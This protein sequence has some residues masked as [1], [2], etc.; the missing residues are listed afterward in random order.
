M[1]GR[2]PGV[3][4]IESA[5]GCCSF[6]PLRG[7]LRVSDLEKTVSAQQSAYR[8]LI[9]ILLI[10][11]LFFTFAG[12]PAPDVNEAHYLAKAKHYWQPDWCAGD[13]F[14]ESGEAH[15]FFYWTLG[16]LNLFLP[17]PAVA[18][19]GRLV[20][21]GALAWAWQRLSFAIVPRPMMSVLTAGLFLFFLERFH[22]AGEWVVGGVEA[23]G[24]A[25]VL[26]LLALEAMTRGRWR[27]VWIFLGLATSLHVLVGGWSWFAAGWA[28]LVCG[29]YRPPL[30]SLLP[31]MA[32]GLLL[33]L[34]GLIAAL[35]LN[36]GVDPAVVREADSLYVYRRLA[37]HLVFH[38][39]PHDAMARHATLLGIWLAA[40]WLSPCRMSDQR[41]GQRPLRGFVVGAV[42]LSAIGI[43]IDQS[44]L[45]R[46][47]LA[48]PLLKFY[49]YRLA[50]AA[51]P[52]GAALALAGLVDHWWSQR[53][54]SARWLL[55][56][57]TLL[58]AGHLGWSHYQRRLDFR[59]GA[60]VQMLPRWPHDSARTR[61]KYED[62][63]YVCGWIEKNT[64]ADSVFVTPRFQQTFKWYAGRAEVCA[65]KDIPQ[66][67]ASLVRWW[68][69][70]R[71]LYSGAVRR[72][73]LVMH[74]EQRLVELS[75]RYGG[76][77]IVLD[78]DFS[79]RGL[80]LPRVFPTPWDDPCSY[81][82]YRVPQGSEGVDSSGP[83][84]T[85]SASGNGYGSLPP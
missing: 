44:L 21:W 30:R 83:P 54:R 1:T 73:G 22:L 51:L 12:G 43:A 72:G 37:H 8:A 11:L 41:L 39:F 65:W 17:L 85:Y 76:Q 28:W 34:P 10:F 53:P 15:L 47:D 6:L 49:W 78:R 32:A 46:L 60:D 62:W 38:R 66:D 84:V 50:D 24:L 16:W 25:Y 42:M 52:V 5:G 81:E 68:R 4:E 19:I 27:R 14:L 3:Q 31:S 70:Q 48:A 82:V 59:P 74:G 29:R 45:Y 9:E 80:L 63:L 64:P 18:W 55:A 58:A 36:A 67:P 20:T 13:L 35:S 57:L 26:V 79:R 40:C 56:V 71:A 69:R 33:A 23:K 7:I 77:Y 2:L 61:E 75:R